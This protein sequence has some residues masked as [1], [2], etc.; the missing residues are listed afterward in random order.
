MICL[1][2]LDTSTELLSNDYTAPDIIPDITTPL[3][4]RTLH[5]IP[6]GG[7]ANDSLIYYIKF[8]VPDNKQ[9]DF[10]LTESESYYYLVTYFD[11]A[12]SFDP[13]DLLLGSNGR[14]A[15]TYQGDP[16]LT[17]WACKYN[18]RRTEFIAAFQPRSKFNS[19]D[20]GMVRFTIDIDLGTSRD[21]FGNLE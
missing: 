9:F 15:T 5:T 18:G 2:P 21:E 1:L 7:A 20:D 12:E 11:D 6:E 16:V 8:T 13:N 17:K 19:L 4:V 14:Y 3:P 10:H